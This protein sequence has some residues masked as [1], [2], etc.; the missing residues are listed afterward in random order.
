[1]PVSE[2]S[3]TFRVATAMPCERAIAAIWQS[4]SGIGPAHTATRGGDFRIGAARAA[5]EG[6][7]TVREAGSE[8]SFQ[9]LP[10]IHPGAARGHDREAEAQL[11]LAD[12]REVKA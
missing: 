11:R 9:S 6:K 5:V 3:P 2:K 10:P 8:H 1:M 12:R 7:D 4:A